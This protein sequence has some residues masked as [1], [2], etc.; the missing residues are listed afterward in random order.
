MFCD[1]IQKLGGVVVG[2]VSGRL[3]YL[4]IGGDGNPCWSYACYGRKV[5]KAI[6]LRKA[7]AE[8]VIVHEYD[9]HD[10]LEDEC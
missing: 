4:F 8:I 3:N 5:E 7:G 1:K 6:E 2:S 10:A 9:L